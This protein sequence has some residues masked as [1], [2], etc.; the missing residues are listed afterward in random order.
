MVRAGFHPWD[1]IAPAALSGILQHGRSGPPWKPD[2]V[3]FSRVRAIATS[4]FRFVKGTVRT[5][6]ELRGQK[7]LRAENV[8]FVGGENQAHVDTGL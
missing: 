5:I 3:A 1:A 6:T 7:N 8:S 2:G 4:F